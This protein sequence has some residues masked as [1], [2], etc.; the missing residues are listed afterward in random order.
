MY[1]VLDTMYF[2]VI[3]LVRQGHDAAHCHTNVSGGMH[4]IS[5]GLYL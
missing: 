1:D 5:V 4:L 2:H 3:H